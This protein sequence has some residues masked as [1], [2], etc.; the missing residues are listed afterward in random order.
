ML[1]CSADNSKESSLSSMFKED[2]EANEGEET[3]KTHAQGDDA[4][5]A[6]GS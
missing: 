2:L 6:W 5:G 1:A 3:H 4:A